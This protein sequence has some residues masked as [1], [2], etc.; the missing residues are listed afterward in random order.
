MVL[1]LACP[2]ARTVSH[3]PVTPPSCVLVFRW[4][5]LSEIS[6]IIVEFDGKQHCPL[7]G[8]QH[9]L[10]ALVHLMLGV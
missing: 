9:L 8:E 1:K 3:S 4:L 10:M 7:E 5:Y 6:G 2:L